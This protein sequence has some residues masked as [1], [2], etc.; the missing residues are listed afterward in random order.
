MNKNKDKLH[1]LVGVISIEARKL[2]KL[3]TSMEKISTQNI[4]I[5]FLIFA[6]S[7]EYIKPVYH[8]PQSNIDYVS[9]EKKTSLDIPEARNFLYQNILKYCNTK[10]ISPILWLLDE[11][12]EIDSRANDYLPLLI[13]LKEQKDIDVL[14]GSLEGDSP[15]SA[16]SGMQ[17]QLFDLIENLKW[18]NSLN[19]I[20]LLP[21]RKKENERLREK[22]PDYY[23][24]LT[25]RHTEHLCQT[26]WI[27]PKYQGE[28]IKEAKERLYSGLSSILVGKNIFRPLRQNKAKVFENCLFMGANTFV[29]NLDTL[30][31]KNPTIKIN[32]KNIRRS[33]MLWALINQEL[34]NKKIVSGNFPVLHNRQESKEQELSLDKTLKDIRGSLI[35]NALK[36]YFNQG[37]I[38]FDNTLQIQINKKI[39]VVTRSFER[40]L[41]HIETLEKINN[42]EIT[43]F[44]QQLRIFYTLDNLVLINSGIKQFEANKEMVLKQFELTSTPFV[45][46]NVCDLE[47]RHGNFKQYDIGDNDIKILSKTAI[48]KMDKNIPPLVRIHS[49]CCNSEVFGA[50]DCDCA[51]QLDAAM[52]AI[53]YHGSG[54]I[55][56]LDQEGRGHGYGKKIAIVEKMQDKSIDTYQ[57]CENLDLEKDIRNYKSVAD[58]LK[59]IGFEEIRLL[60]NNPAKREG[61]EQYGVKVSQVLLISLFRQENIAYLLSK[62]EKAGH[63]N[64]IITEQQI[65]ERYL[66]SSNCIYFCRKEDEYG[67][68]SN[69]ADYPLV[70]ND[71]YWRTSEH[72]Y[73]AQKFNN[74]P[75]IAK[76]IQAAKTP[77]LAKSI[78][79]NNSQEVD[80][81]WKDKKIPF[82]CNALY[83]K[84]TQNAEI[85]DLLLSTGE[86]Y[87]IELS[88]H[89]EYWGCKGDGAGKNILGKLL[90]YLRDQFRL[91]ETYNGT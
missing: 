74:S 48:E 17:L 8:L 73:Q 16:F 42:A 68:F 15:N 27:E 50:V 7:A 62:Q 88:K 34:C 11:D 2:R 85:R 9:L 6:N 33:E 49:S 89:D 86:K 38:N 55:F 81:D 32:G 75:D 78:A 26:F 72:Y 66:A 77:I 84:L 61:L 69:F 90:M 13:E 21:D 4:Q 22:Y 12:I 79:E 31:I 82:M 52:E 24:D 67:A 63:Q 76:Q 5:D 47:N 19:Q 57:A 44:C 91:L 10:K 46:K 40:T 3:F 35:F 59:R 65:I 36:Q 64:L 28:T 54:I 70:I 87:I 45:I 60:S 23:Y 51:S 58:F 41:V 18:L 39:G 53:N 30:K 80:T 37:K 14:I 20:D 83:K 71:T 29:F 56:Y 25:S 43:K 1:L